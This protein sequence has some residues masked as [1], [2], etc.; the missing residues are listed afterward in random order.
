MNGS[1]FPSVIVTD[2][3]DPDGQRER[4][5]ARLMDLAFNAHNARVAEREVLNGD[6]E[7]WVG[8]VSFPEG[9]DVYRIRLADGSVEECTVEP[10]EDGKIWSKDLSEAAAFHSMRVVNDA[11][12]VQK[13]TEVLE[14]EEAVKQRLI[15]EREAG[16]KGDKGINTL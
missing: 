16:D 5:H 14:A 1:T 8:A 4:T 12:T 10:R 2:G 15:A 7:W 13:P 11:L 6:P 3:G 9:K